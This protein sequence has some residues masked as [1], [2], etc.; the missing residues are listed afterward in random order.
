MPKYI[1]TPDDMY[2]T[3]PCFVCGRDIID[4]DKETCCVL[5]EQEMIMFQEDWEWLLYKDYEGEDT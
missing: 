1:P 3:K 5:C 2:S 4:D